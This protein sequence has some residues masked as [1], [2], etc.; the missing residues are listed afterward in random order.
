MPH[1][2]NI[3]SATEPYLK[4]LVPTLKTKDAED[5]FKDGKL[6]VAGLTLLPAAYPSSL[7]PKGRPAHRWRGDLGI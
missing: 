4:S 7:L 1:V 2:L 5:E 3:C 6:A